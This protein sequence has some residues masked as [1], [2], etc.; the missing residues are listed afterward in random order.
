MPNRHII[1]V[2]ASAGG[3]EA[4]QALVRTLPADFPGTLFVTMHFPSHGTSVLPRILSRVSEVPASHAVDG[5]PI[6]PGRIYVAPPDFHLLLT[7]TGVHLA[8]GPKESGHRPAV[9]PMF[10]SAAVAFGARVIGVVLTG[11]LDDGTSGMAAIKRRGGLVVIQDPDEALFPSMPQSV[12]E[13]VPVDRVVGIRDLAR[14][15]RE[16]MD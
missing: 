1:V 16:L 10:R 15:L 3:V 5:E 2:G 6:L 7:T 13:H 14:T 4:L 8:R 9:D 11:S 12:H